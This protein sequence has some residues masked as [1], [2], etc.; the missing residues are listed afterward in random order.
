ME[1]IISKEELDKLMKLKGKLR[2]ISFKTQADFILK[3]EGEEA[4]RR[5]EDAMAKLGYPLKYKKIRSTDFYPLGLLA[6]NMIAIKSL[7]N[8]NDKKFQEMGSVEAKTS[9]LV[10]RL[11]MRH[12]C[13][14]NMMVKEAPKMW[15][16]HYTVG[17][18]KILK[19][20]KEKR[21]V[22]I[23][24]ENFFC[25]PL[26]CQDLVGYFSSILQMVIGKEI[27]CEEAKC[28][29]RGDEYHE[30]LLKW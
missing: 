8:Y 18:L 13:S 17:N 12:F 16:E 21:F 19:H 24:L 7:F 25:H 20:D 9:S 4:L 27:S 14:L 6:V 30:F 26:V 23:R 5:L 11:F 1:P 3:K 2:G 28:V 10:I 22:I 15:R 29:H